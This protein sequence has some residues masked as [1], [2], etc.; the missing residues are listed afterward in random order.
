METSPPSLGMS[1]AS[2][3]KHNLKVL[4]RRDPS[5]ISIFDQFSHVCVYHHDGKKWEK[6]GYEGSMF[7][8]ER[9]VCVPLVFFF[10]VC[11]SFS[12]TRTQR[13]V[14]PPYGFYVL[15]RMGMEDYIQHIYPEDDISAHGS[16]LI[17]RSYPDYMATRMAGIQAKLELGSDTSFPD[18]FADVYKIE[19]IEELDAKMKGRSSIV[20]L[21]MFATDARESMIEVMRR[22]V[23]TCCVVF[24]R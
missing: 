6:H 1:P 23:F 15:N 24:G 20:G 2:R 3:Y 5:I 4:R 13:D 12:L 9:C 22:S 17:I 11:F 8:F 18:K 19:G 7:L 16:Y 21:W 14:Y 10:S